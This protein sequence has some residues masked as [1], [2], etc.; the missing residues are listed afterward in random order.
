M[1]CYLILLLLKNYF[2]FIQQNNINIGYRCQTN[3]V[4]YA[5][6][7]IFIYG[8]YVVVHLLISVMIV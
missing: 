6:K 7:Q 1:V 2:K 3:L 8:K 4:I 5:L